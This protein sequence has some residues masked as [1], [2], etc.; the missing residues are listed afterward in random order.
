[1]VNNLWIFCLLL[2]IN[3][4]GN[5]PNNSCFIIA[6]IIGSLLDLFIYTSEIK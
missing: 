6:I 3:Q 1:M 2:R 4:I 5:N